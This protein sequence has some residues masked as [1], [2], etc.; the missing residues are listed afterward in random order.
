MTDRGR[1]VRAAIGQLSGTRVVVLGL[2]SGVL[3]VAMYAAQRA[4]HGG[5]SGDAFTAGLVL[6]TIITLGIFVLY[7]WLLAWCRRPLSR[8]VR[9]TAFGF[10]VLFGL[11]WLPVAPVFSSDVFAYIAHGYVAL[12]LGDNPALRSQAW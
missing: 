7:V 3:Y 12:E 11:F 5:P 9:L 10:P 8:R 6:Y 2:V 1:Y 4:I